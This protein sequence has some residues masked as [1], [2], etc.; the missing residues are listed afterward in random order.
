MNS[1]NNAINHEEDLTQFLSFT[2]GDENYGINILRVQEIRGW[3]EVR[4]IPD[5][6]DYIKGVLNLRNIIVPIVDLRI[7][8]GMQNVEYRPTTVIIV[9]S[10][11]R[12]DD[13]RVM[14]VVVDSVS[15]VLDV[16]PA[17]IRKPPNLGSSID[18]RYMNGM[19]MVDERVVIVLNSDKLL[20]YDELA[21]LQSLSVQATK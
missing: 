21:Q 9:L 11:E 4:A 20:D 15:D 12:T 1:E 5:T 3:E 13:M 17:D 7:R 6:P 8:F 19:V 18:T 14:G 16:E 2:L 10:V